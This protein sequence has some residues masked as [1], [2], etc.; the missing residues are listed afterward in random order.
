MALLE[1]IN[2]LKQAGQSDNQIATSLKEQGYP[3]AQISEALS[4]SKIK[5]AIYDSQQ[6]SEDPEQMQSSI[7]TQQNQQVMT[8]P[9]QSAETGMQNQT[10][11]MAQQYPETYPGY[12]QQYSQ[13]YAP[14]ESY[15]GQESYYSQVIDRETVRD[16]SRQEAEEIVKKI[17]SEVESLTKIKTDMNF[18]IQ[19][20]DNR[21]TRIESVIQDLQS[22]IIHKMGEYGESIQGISQDLQA[23]QEAFSKMVNPLLDKTR[24]AQ[25][26]NQNQSISAKSNLKKKKPQVNQDSSSGTSFEDY[27]RQ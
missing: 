26:S 13:E 10:A 21:L 24:A 25:I 12:N 14:Q 27:F 6:G 23:T 4:Q 16:I 11:E 15:Q 1:Q 2:K 18:E 9:Q 22:A 7:M 8:V 19:N 5:S 17:R 3:L 20:M